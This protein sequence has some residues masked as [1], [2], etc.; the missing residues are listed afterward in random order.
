MTEQGIIEEKVEQA[1]EILADAEADVWLTFARETSEIDEPCLP[2]ILGFDV[3]WPTMILVTPDRSTAIIGRHDAPNA[4]DRGVHEVVPYDASLADAFH[5]FLTN[6]DPDAIAVNY[7][8]D[9]NVADGL[10][11]GLYLRLQ[12]L[13]DGTDYEGT[14]VS[15]DPI[16][17]ELRGI[18]SATERDRIVAAAEETEALFDE[19]AAKW[20]PDWTEATI[21]EYLHGRMEEEGYGSA[22][23][24]DYCPTVHAGGEA[25]VGHTLP[26]DRTLPP[27]DVLHVDFGV[28]KDGYAADIQRLYY[29]PEEDEGP[30]A[31]LRAAFE[32]VRAAIDAGL[33]ALE[34]GVEGHVVDQAAREAVISR[35]RD[36]YQ[37]AFGH[38][39]GR[40]AHDG[41]ALLGPLWDRYGDQPRREVRAGEIYTAE[42]GVETEYGYIGQEEMVLITDDGPEFV[43][44][45]QREL[46]T[47]EP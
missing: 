34:P 44:D 35:G 16:V 28:V 5:E 8:R 6:V 4:E 7:S 29:Y 37:H 22:W 46:R 27:G 15:A 2:Y 25:P 33:D 39:V 19:M 45:P 3:V 32:D 23:S 41:G 26:G 31:D 21:S 17:S 24:W 38:Q 1:R 11:H 40:N 36:E 12:S 9:N 13:L 18:K 14:L 42:L 30:P 47:I 10:T 43:V 20:S